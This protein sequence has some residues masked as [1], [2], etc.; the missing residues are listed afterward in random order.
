MLCE[1]PAF[2]T[3][4]LLNGFG[5]EVVRE[6]SYITHVDAQ[7][8]Y[9]VIVECSGI[10]SVVVLAILAFL[11]GIIYVRKPLKV[12]LLVVASV[13]LAYGINVLRL[14]AVVCVGHW[15]GQEASSSFHFISGYVT[16][17]IAVSL[18]YN[19]APKK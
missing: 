2:L 4:S 15:F 11:Y 1:L 3:T 8:G 12:V 10:R 16:F 14:M 17:F 9:E 13:P 6:G 7:W 5:M 18:M 19:W